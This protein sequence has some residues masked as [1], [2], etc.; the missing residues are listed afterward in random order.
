MSKATEATETDTELY[1]RIFAESAAEL[2]KAL[3][4]NEGDE[5]RKVVAGISKAAMKAGVDAEA[6]GALAHLLNTHGQ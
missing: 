4:T 5:R 2:I 3:K 6:A 1:T